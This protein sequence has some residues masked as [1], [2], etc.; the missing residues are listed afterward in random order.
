MKEAVAGAEKMSGLVDIPAFTATGTSKI[1]NTGDRIMAVVDVGGVYVP[2]YISTGEGGKASVPTGKWYPVF[3]RHTSG[4][5][6]KGG[7]NAINQFYGSKMLELHAKRL[8]NSV[9][10]I[11]DDMTVPA[12]KKAGDTV[13]NKDMQPMSHSEANGNPKEFMKRINNVLVKI[14]SKPFYK[15]GIAESARESISKTLLREFSIDDNGDGDEEDTLRKFARMW[16]NGDNTVQ[17]QVE[18]ILAQSGWEIGELESEEGGAFVIQSGDENGDSYIGFTAEDLTEGLEEASLVNALTWPQVVN[19]VN[20]AMKATGWKVQRMGED[21][22]MYTT[23]G[24]ESDDQWYMAVIDNVGNDHFSY[25]LGTVEEGDPHIDDA[26]RGTLPNT[27]ASVSELINEIREGFGLGDRVQEAT[28]HGREVTLGV[29]V[30]QGQHYFVY[31]RDPISQK[32]KKVIHKEPVKKVR[33][34]RQRHPR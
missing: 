7:E 11:L 2:Y 6:N 32:V 10:N 29:P 23:K 20:S 15:D 31:Q 21:A 13:I 9:G 12:M 19:K 4:W 16:Y 1:V 17:Q 26:F 8:N 33:Q 3:G 24:S 14:G 34:V 22:F 27:E 5:L 25:A 18:K 28:Y 30:K